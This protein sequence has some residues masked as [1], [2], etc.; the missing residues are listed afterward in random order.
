M[1][2]HMSNQFETLISE[3][4]KH[5]DLDKCKKS[6][7][8]YKEYNIF[9]KDLSEID[10]EYTVKF[11]FGFKNIIET[12]IYNP[13]YKINHIQ[14]WPAWDKPADE[15]KQPISTCR[16]EGNMELF[17]QHALFMKLRY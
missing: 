1:I 8:N 11:T 6:I 14:T 3:F 13:E 17:K 4:I 15:R 16:W 9:K 12:T 5:I 7:E 2:T 10:V